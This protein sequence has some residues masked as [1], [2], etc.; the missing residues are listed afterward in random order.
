MLVR[1]AV[2][3]DSRL[4]TELAVRLRA[5]RSGVI[6]E[7]LAAF[8]HEIQG[9]AYLILRDQSDAEEVVID[10]LMMAWRKSGSLRDDAALRTWLLRIATRQAL[11]RR[12][13]RHPTR[14]L[15][16]SHAL[17]APSAD[18]PSADRMAMAEAMN[19]L[20]AQMR[21][22]IAL[23]HLAGLSVPQIGQVLGKSPNTV[24][25]QLRE[26][27]ARLRVALE[28]PPIASRGGRATDVRRA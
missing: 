8:G 22:A 12:R 2:G 14:S 13:R 28:V 17:A 3:K 4:Q 19:S 1:N 27:L 5:H 11:S 24:K 21:A 26:G 15:D 16:L 9:I 6:A 23:H 7:L 25:T 20:P 18:G 10:T